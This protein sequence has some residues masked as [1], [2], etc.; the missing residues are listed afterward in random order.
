MRGGDGWTS[1]ELKLFGTHLTWLAKELHKLWVD[2][3]RHLY[4]L[5]TCS[6]R[7]ALI[8]FLW[9]LAG[10]PKRNPDEARPISVASVLLRAWL[11]ACSDA[12]PTPDVDQWACKKGSSVLSATPSWLAAC[13]DAVEGAEVDLEKAFD[14]IEHTIAEQAHVDSG[15]SPIVVATL[16]AAWKGPR[17]MHVAGEISS[18]PIWP[19]RSLAQG[20]GTAP[21][22]MAAILAPW[23]PPSVRVWKYVDDRRCS[24]P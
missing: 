21:C 23:K 11:N 9:R 18:N 7:L 1:S 20:D 17:Y 2:T 12:M 5:G 13:A 24:A 4:H 15:V 10:I 6:T 22:G 16:K 3:A 14:N 8:A 19:S